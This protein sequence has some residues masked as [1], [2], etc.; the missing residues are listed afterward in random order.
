METKTKKVE[1][2]G[3]Y[4]AFRDYEHQ[5][6][7]FSWSTE[8]VNL[9]GDGKSALPYG[10][11]RSYGDS[12]LNDGG[13]L[14]DTTSLNRFI[15]F[16]RN[17][18]ILRCE[19]G[20]TLEEVLDL[21][22][23]QGWFLPVSPGTKF[24][25]VGGAMANDIHGKNHAKNGTFGCHVRQF[26]LLR[27]DGQRLICS[28]DENEDWFRA[29][30]GGLG[31]TGLILWAEI[32]LKPITSPFWDLET[33]KF[34]TLEEFFDLAAESEAAGYEYTVA[35]IDSMAKGSALGRGW[36]QR[37]NNAKPPFEQSLTLPKKRNLTVPFNFPNFTL[38]TLSI[39]AFN[40]LLYYRQLTKRKRQLIYY[41]PFFYPLDM[42]GR[43]NRGYGKRGFLQYQF[44]VPYD[45][46][47][48][49][50]RTILEKISRSKTLPF[51][52]VFKTFGNIESPG[53]LSFP[54]KG[55]TLAIDFPNRGQATLDLLEELDQIVRLNGGVVYPA[56]DTRMS[57]ASFQAFYPQWK[58]FAAYVDPKFSSSF[59]R[60]VTASPSEQSIVSTKDSAMRKSLIIGATSAI[61]Q[62]TCK[63]F[64]KDGDA[65]YLVGRNEEK[66]TA[67]AKDLTV[68]GA[69]QVETQ[70]LDLTDFAQHQPLVD[71]ATESL[72]GLDT[73][74]IAHGTLTDQDAAQ[75]DFDLVKTELDINFTSYVSLLTII[76]NQFET[77]K[78]GT[79][80]V[81]S[82]VAG[83]RGR[84]SNYVYGTA[85]AA[86]STFTQGLRGRLSKAG[87]SVITI[88]PGM[89]DT[90]M[91]AHL[92]KGLL[93]AKPEDVAKGIYR[94]IEKRKNV[95]YLPS[96]WSLIMT[97]IKLIP[98]RIFKKLT[99]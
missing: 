46:N 81:I 3:R 62:E 42:I 85:K 55:V 17:Q 20:V 25:T 76:G 29:T 83:D 79:I 37:A 45:D 67:L 97:I 90:P 82:S 40:F 35:W 56:K 39:K 86:V 71:N 66:L 49:T 12:C 16:D 93:F 23:L 41:E 32:Q 53:M 98:E 18:G 15:S 60:R 65:L 47:Y 75:T 50:I 84:Q 2:W 34:N 1:S 30:I 88:K 26:E 64:A 52:N 95:V 44:V 10:L 61:A 22:V 11:G 54:Q 28:L 91:T 58:N 99:F 5:V 72:S 6:Q 13:I 69:K 89:V 8:T 27:S 59:W 92:K 74:L 4:A 63:R 24:V 77:Q 14:V 78:R 70:V 68:R 19:S 38:N 57:A 21:I 94:A 31:L 9:N 80:V 33:I 36:F 51:L 48:Q 96:Y 87:V 7:T 43:W 73:V